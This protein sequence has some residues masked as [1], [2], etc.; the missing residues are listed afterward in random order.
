MALVIVLAEMIAA[1]ALSP[2]DHGPAARAGN[3]GAPRVAETMTKARKIK[4]TV[5]T[6]ATKA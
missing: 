4:L 6:T 3:T 2:L 1:L 5:Y